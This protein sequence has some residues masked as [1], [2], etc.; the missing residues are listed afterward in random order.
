MYV[1]AVQLKNLLAIVQGGIETGRNDLALQAVRRMDAI[2][3]AVQQSLE[4]DGEGYYVS[5]PPVH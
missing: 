4:T 3:I 5:H 1:K 2:L